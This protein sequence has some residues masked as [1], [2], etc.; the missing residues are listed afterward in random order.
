M[1]AWERRER[2]GGRGTPRTFA[3]GN[4]GDELNA[5]LVTVAGSTLKQLERGV[6]FDSEKRDDGER[7]QADECFDVVGLL[8]CCPCTREGEPGNAATKPI[9]KDKTMLR[10]F[11]GRAGY[12][13]P[14]R[15]DIE[16]WK[17]ADLQRCRPL[18]IW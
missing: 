12:V 13:E 16:Y 7:R 3:F 1:I 9:T 8:T 17:S 14:W 18:S 2:C 11:A 4:A 6:A 15:I 10:V 5:L